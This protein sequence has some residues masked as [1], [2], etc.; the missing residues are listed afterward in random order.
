MY[1]CKA[2]QDIKLDFVSFNKYIFSKIKC[3]INVRPTEVVLITK[4]N[5]NN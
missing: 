2:N 3:L 5:L 4:G 1:V